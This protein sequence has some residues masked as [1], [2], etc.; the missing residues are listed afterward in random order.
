MFAL[1]GASRDDTGS[2][3]SCDVSTE[4]DKR[5]SMI[6]EEIYHMN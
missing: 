2:T 1:S 4:Y 5:Q 3:S 6:R